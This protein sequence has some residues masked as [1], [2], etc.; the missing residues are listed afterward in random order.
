[1]RIDCTFTPKSLQA[2]L[3]DFAAQSGKTFDDQGRIVGLATSS[4]YDNIALNFMANSAILAAWRAPDKE[5]GNQTR[6]KAVPG[7]G[8]ITVWVTAVDPNGS[9]DLAAAQAKTM[10]NMVNSMRDRDGQGEM[11]SCVLGPD[12][13]LPPLSNYSSDDT[14]G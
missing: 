1:M 11:G 14:S 5:F 3:L 12:A 2:S 6:M 10:S 4:R 9:L 7:S 8:V 13:P